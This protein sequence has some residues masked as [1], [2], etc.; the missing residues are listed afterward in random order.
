[1]SMSHR[2]IYPNP[3]PEDEGGG[4]DWIMT[5][6]DL[7]TLLLVFF[8]LIV[9][10]STLDVVKY[11]ALVG[12][13]EEAFGSKNRPAAPLVS[14]DLPPFTMPVQMEAFPTHEE[15]EMKEVE[16][17]KV[18][19]DLARLIEEMGPEAPLEL[20][21]SPEG[22]RLRMPGHIMFSLASAELSEEA[23]PILTRLAPILGRYPYRIWVEG[24][25]DDLP[26]QTPVYPSNWELSAARA[27][28]VVRELIDRRG[29]ERSRLAAVGYA[30]TRP[31]VPNQDEA[32]RSA[33]RRVEILLS[34][35]GGR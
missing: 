23:Q 28:N 32:S 18:E 17:V 14:E 3:P 19:E 26:I 4:G 8:V 22:L 6:G 34:Q 13:L 20:V 27:G 21:E 30:D 11:R 7:M 10:F 16:R 12:S 1:M 9:S 15:A 25:S 35:P 5:Y 2:R 31:V 33:N 29:L 24:H